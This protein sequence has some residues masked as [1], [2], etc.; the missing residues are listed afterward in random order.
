MHSEKNVQ[1]VNPPPNS[2]FSILITPRK[3]PLSPRRDRPCPQDPQAITGLP[4]YFVTVASFLLSVLEFYAHGTINYVL[5]CVGP[6]S[7]SMFLKF[8]QVVFINGALFY[9]WVVFCCLNMSKHLFTYSSGNKHLVVS[10]MGILGI[11]MLWTF[12]HKPLCEQM[13]SFLLS[14]YWKVGV[15]NSMV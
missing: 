11:K 8:I 12:A 10:S 4:V 5:F 2:T 7:L 14:Q 6:L 15:M 9:C 3:S 13:F 1:S